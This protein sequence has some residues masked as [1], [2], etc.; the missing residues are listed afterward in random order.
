MFVDIHQKRLAYKDINSLLW[1][2]LFDEKI[3]KGKNLKKFINNVFILTDNHKINE[4][5]KI[6]Y[7]RFVE[8]I[9]AIH[10]IKWYEEI[11]KWLLGINDFSK[12][13][14]LLLEI[15]VW[16]NLLEYW[17][18]IEFAD[19]ILDW[20]SPDIVMIN[21]G[22]KFYYECYSLYDISSVRSD[23]KILEKRIK[24]IIFEKNKKYKSQDWDWMTIIDISILFLLETDLMNKYYD[25]F[26][27][28]IDEYVNN[29]VL[30][31]KGVLFQFSIVDDKGSYNW[32][33]KCFKTCFNYDEYIFWKDNN[34]KF[35]NK[36][37]FTSLL[38]N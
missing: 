21:K 18:N 22:N 12:F 9:K 13:Y 20:K 25:S 15:N 32:F 27:Y 37:W 24:D 33:K 4:I 6:N 31:T 35:E 29:H 36:T 5:R 1:I 8:W 30:N 14:S 26:F 11:Q 17:Y 16:K 19:S 3:K 10:R 23:I 38:F 7:L 2:D 28:N 34:Q